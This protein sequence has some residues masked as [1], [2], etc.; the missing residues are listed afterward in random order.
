MTIDIQTYTLGPLENKTYLIN[1]INSKEAAIIDP[2]IPSKQISSWIEQ[3]GITLKYILITHAHFDHIGGA[4]WFQ[5]LSENHIPIALHEK[6]MEL[7]KEGGGAKNFG[8]DFDPGVTPD[9]IVEDQQ[10][11][12]LGNSTFKVLFTPGHSPGHV[13]YAFIDDQ[14]AFCGDVIFFHSVGRTDLEHGSSEV[15]L[16]SIHQKI[17][18]LSDNTILYPGH[19]KPTTV[20]EE[21]KNNPYV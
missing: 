6:D 14:A 20:E 8:F 13:T 16:T 7:W 3:N 17:F 4:K 19:G 21:K 18:T 2:S 1:D 15:L 10:E 9:L 11:F 5:N 12:Q